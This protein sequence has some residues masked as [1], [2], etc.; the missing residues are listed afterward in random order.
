MNT[1]AN[2]IDKGSSEDAFFESYK[3]EIQHILKIWNKQSKAEAIRQFDV[4]EQQSIQRRHWKSLIEIKIEIGVQYFYTGDYMNASKKFEESEKLALK[5]QFTERIPVIYFSL[6]SCCSSLELYDEATIYAN[7]AIKI[8]R[9][10]NDSDAIV[11][12]VIF[13]ANLYYKSKLYE[14]SLALLDE[15]E[16][17]LSKS[18]L[19]PDIKDLNA[20]IIRIVSNRGLGQYTETLHNLR[21]AELMLEE[22]EGKLKDVHYKNSYVLIHYQYLD[23]YMLLDD[24]SDAERHVSAITD[25]LEH[26]SNMFEGRYY[27][28]RITLGKYFYLK[29]EYA[30]AMEY[31][32]ENLKSDFKVFTEYD[33]YPYLMKCYA[34]LGDTDKLI[35]LADQQESFFKQYINNV[36][37]SESYK[38][39]YLRER[40]ETK[41]EL[42][43][44]KKILEN[45]NEMNDNLQR[46]ANIASHDLREP[47]RTIGSFAQLAERALQKREYDKLE[48]YLGFVKQGANSG[49]KLVSNLYT[50]AKQGFESLVVEEVDCQKLIEL[51]VLQLNN[52]I[53]RQKGKVEIGKL[54]AIQSVRSGLLLL[55]QNLISNA[56]KFIP[57][58]RQPL[59]K[60][61]CLKEGETYHFTVSD[62]GIGIP[63]DKCADIFK[64]FTRLNSR[65]Q[66]DGTGLGLAT[67]KRIVENLGGKISVESEVDVGTTFTVSLTEIEQLSD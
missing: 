22:L 11:E 5:H 13:I 32:E 58:E 3:L 54:P 30:K 16:L 17:L 45:V 48:S 44:Q 34:V 14:E 52:Q 55:F 28:A 43:H 19:N 8:A 33:T 40:H 49:Q 23:T 56:L 29:K 38:Y 2:K 35:Q 65:Q 1:K 59:V 12:G 20:L 42:E 25:W 18:S 64:A 37:S 27:Y 6:G 7:K 24:L 51:I 60:I 50:Y 47:L 67:C 53:S 41:I 61:D 26:N 15:N 57:P 10:L 66:Y 46:F 62:N 63:K 31:F 21:K 4:L 39:E 9:E 36:R